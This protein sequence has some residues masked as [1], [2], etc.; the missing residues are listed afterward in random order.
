M[1][2]ARVSSEQQ[3]SHARATRHLQ[4]LLMPPSRLQWS[5]V[6][7]GWMVLIVVLSVTAWTLGVSHWFV[8]RR[9]P[10]QQQQHQQQE[11]EQEQEPELLY[12]WLVFVRRVIAFVLHPWLTS[13]AAE[14]LFTLILLHQCRFIERLVGSRRFGYL[15]SLHYV[16]TLS[17]VLL[18]WALFAPFSATLSL[19]GPHALLTSILVQY[20][21]WKPALSYP[22]A[23]GSAG[24]VKQ[25]RWM[26]AILVLQWILVGPPHVWLLI[27]CGVVSGLLQVHDPVVLF[28]RAPPV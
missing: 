28:M 15:L 16:L 23:L 18:V 2:E 21:R 7:S 14:C 27:L 24:K 1:A 12:A 4:R 17:L 25:H 11:Q 8:V 3:P 5:P 6:I 19:Q 9:W 22:V 26:M 10:Q 13:S 20:A